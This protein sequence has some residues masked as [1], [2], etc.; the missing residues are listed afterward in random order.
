M[1]LNWLIISIIGAVIPG[2]TFVESATIAA[3]NILSY[4]P[5]TKN[6][7]TDYGPSIWAAYNDCI[8]TKQS[9]V[10]LVPAGKTFDVNVFGTLGGS[11][12]KFQLDGTLNFLFNPAVNS[13]TLLIWSHATNVTL[14]GTGTIVGNGALWR[15]NNSVTAYPS[16]PRLI[17]FQ[18]SESII[19]TGKLVL[20]NSPMFHITLD[21]CNNS[22]VE[23]VR[24]V[25]DNIGAT[26]GIDISGNNNIVRNVAVQ[27][28]DE[29]VTVKSP[30]NGIFVEN[31]VCTLTGGCQMGT[32]G[33]TGGVAAVE[34]I[35][36]R[37][38]T[39]IGSQTAAYI[40]SYPTTNGYIR[41]VLYEDFKV[42]NTLYVFGIN[43]YWCHG[44]CPAA[45]GNLAISNV[46][47]QN[48]VGSQ[49][50]SSAR[51][52]VLL[53]CLNDNG[54]GCKDI[55]FVNDSVTSGKGVADTISYACGTGRPSLP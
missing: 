1:K 5:T 4:P 17:R 40:K 51:P 50:S 7:T 16:R 49:A 25:A 35:H 24:I 21:T 9:D 3:C 20:L 38:V 12:W 28:G 8:K 55:H 2:S 47:F 43:T 48:F 33:A 52:V 53:Q 6:G 54:D 23:G 37:N 10:L 18:Q 46:T 45:T 27:N 26:D 44:T 32:F 36:Y 30:A 15:P 19:I 13:G 41:N 22:L 31:V 14:T 29:C 34:N 11:N 39:M 42:E